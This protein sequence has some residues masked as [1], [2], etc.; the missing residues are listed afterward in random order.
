MALASWE[1]APQP[2]PSPPTPDPVNHDDF[3]Q[4][5][6]TLWGQQDFAY[7]NEDKVSY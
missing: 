2:H 1:P 6:Q 5:R 7:A 4:G 3:N